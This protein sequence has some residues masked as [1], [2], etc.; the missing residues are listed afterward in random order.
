MRSE[1]A[2]VCFSVEI[3]V[4]FVPEVGFGVL[5]LVTVVWDVSLSVGLVVWMKFVMLGCCCLEVFVFG[6]GL[7]RLALPRPECFVMVYGV[8][9]PGLRKNVYVELVLGLFLP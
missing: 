2:S 6:L 1:G 3:C 4:E 8:F 5:I 9:P 7:W